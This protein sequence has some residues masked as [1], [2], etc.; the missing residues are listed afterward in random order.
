VT[1]ERLTYA[2]KLLL[3]A[4][5]ALYLASIA[6]AFLARIV[7]LVYI[8][9]GAVFVAYLVY[10][11]VRLLR[12]RMPLGVAIALVYLAF[13]IVAALA[14]WLVIPGLANDVQAAV[15]NGPQLLAAFARYV[16]DPANPILAHAPPEVRTSLLGLPETSLRWLRT[17]GIET[18][19]HAFGVVRGAVTLIATFVIIPLLS[20]YLI[21]DAENLRAALARFVP[22]DRLEGTQR[23]LVQIDAIV[24]GFIR[25]QLIVAAT[26]GTILT[27][28]LLVLRVP[29]AF[30][31]GLL[32]ALGDLVPMV[33]A[34]L[35]FIPAVGIAFF[36]NGWVNAAIVA[37]I[38]VTLF[39][40][41][42]HVIQPMIVS[43]QVKLSPL[44]VL[45]AI[46]IGA[47][48]GGIFGMLVAVPVAGVL[49]LAVL[50]LIEDREPPGGSP[51]PSA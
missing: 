7:G 15:Q 47:E 24:G 22:A 31:L 14:L 23:F 40:L 43:S 11:I 1:E 48:L 4:V 42:G 46:L 28:A 12:R 8:V 21:A 10:P 44:I 25:G 29:Y 39:Q 37:A 34:V 5:L 30:L 51:K 45:V 35:A 3:F 49:R 32:S 41:E 33:G 36:A 19:G 2:V 6:F 17:H 50:K 18:A 26:V 20:I 13:A 16:D 9:V 38:F 27:I